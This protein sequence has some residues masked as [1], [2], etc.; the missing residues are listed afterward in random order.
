MASIETI[1]QLRGLYRAPS[2]RARDKQLDRLD[3][4]CRR[5]IEASPFLFISSAG[6]DGSADVSPRGDRPGFVHVIDD[7]TL[8]IPDRL[9]NNRLDTLANVLGNPS[10]GLI[11]LVPG[12]H[13]TLRVNGTATIHDDSDL[14][15][16]F[17]VDGKLPV[18][19]LLVAVREAY[20][21]CAKSI[22]RSRLWEEEA[23]IDRSLLPSMGQMLK[24]QIGLSGPVESEDDMIARYR[25]KLY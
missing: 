24:D 21:H 23:K 8:A 20:L 1:D 19:V 22:L 6:A 10:V 12:V 14:L 18:T 25:T 7:R 5:F 15:E 9:G 11:F 3:R 2:G 4:H 13:E 16:G 17:A